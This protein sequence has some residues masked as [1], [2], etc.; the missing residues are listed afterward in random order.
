MGAGGPGPAVPRSH[1]LDLRQHRADRQRGPSPPAA[2]RRPGL[3]RGDGPAAR[4]LSGPGCLLPGSGAADDRAGLT[5]NSV[6]V[7]SGQELTM[8]THRF[9]EAAER[10]DGAAMAALFAEDVTYHT[11]TLTGDLHGKELTLSYLAAGTRIVDD[12]EYTDQIG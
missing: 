11:P 3:L 1:R 5:Q 9:A 2:R 10:R 4:K 12:L 8:R 7:S 6:F